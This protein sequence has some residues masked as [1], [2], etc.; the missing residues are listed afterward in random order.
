LPES[1]IGQDNDADHERPIRP[2][3]TPKRLYTGLEAVAPA[4]GRG[5]PSHD[6]TPPTTPQGTLCK[7]AEY[8]LFP[9][10][11]QPR[12]CL[13]PQ[14]EPPHHA[15][16]PS[17]C[18]GCRVSCGFAGVYRAPLG[19]AA[20]WAA[21]TFLQ[22]GLAPACSASPQEY[23]PHSGH[24]SSGHG[25]ASKGDSAGSIITSSVRRPSAQVSQ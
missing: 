16:P 11:I 13:A 19:T 5:V 21:R 1:A 9:Y 8:C 24:R 6:S 25:S 14:K 15:R 12:A 23:L 4:P 10:P 18:R 7:T 22:K 17:C 3:C 2:T 20:R